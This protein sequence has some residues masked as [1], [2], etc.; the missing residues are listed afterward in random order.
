MSQATPDR[1]PMSSSSSR[2]LRLRMRADVSVQQQVYQGREYW[3]VKD[4]ISLKYYRFEE[5]E[6]KLLQ[7]LDGKTS[8]DQIKRRFD[9]EFAPQ[10][11]ELAELYQFVGMLYRSC[12]LVSDLPNQGL[13]LNRRG[14]KNRS[15]QFRASLSN[16]L[17]IRFKG[18]DP[19]RFLSR[20]NR[21]TKYFF[22]WPAF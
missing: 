14:K 22:S 12:L 8:P 20:L 21:W 5:E 10:K 18:F 9:Y 17:A 13:E 15:Q 4:P 6:F 19:D 2:P 11:I 7:M 1:N 3:V 16:V